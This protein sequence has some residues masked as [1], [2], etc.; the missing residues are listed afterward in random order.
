MLARTRP[1]E[2]F[3]EDCRQRMGIQQSKG[4]RSKQAGNVASF[5][6][7]PYGNTGSTSIKQCRTPTGTQ[8]TVTACRATSNVI[9]AVNEDV[10]AGPSSLRQC[11]CKMQPLDSAGAPGQFVCVVSLSLSCVNLIFDYVCCVCTMERPM[12][13]E[14]VMKLALHRESSR[15]AG[16]EGLKIK[17]LAVYSGCFR[18]IKCVLSHIRDLQLS[19]SVEGISSRK[20][21]LEGGFRLVRSCRPPSQREKPCRMCRWP[22]CCSS[23]Q[24]MNT[25][26][27]VW[28]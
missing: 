24:V 2:T 10:T 19:R 1:G 27:A 26:Q 8:H 12:Y 15:R 11:T 22:I 7:P 5:Q 18:K 9:S 21:K 14:H 25:S 13:D 28:A 20:R 4:P 23:S 16:P 17:L 6:S 3:C